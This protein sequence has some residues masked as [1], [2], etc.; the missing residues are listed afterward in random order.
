MLNGINEGNSDWGVQKQLM[1]EFKLN[2]RKK[3]EVI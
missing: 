3:S 1:G 2:E